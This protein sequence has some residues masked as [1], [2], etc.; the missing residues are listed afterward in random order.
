MD[1]SSR[2][3][4]LVSV[5]SGVWLFQVSGNTLVLELTAKGTKYY[6]DSDLN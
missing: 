6:K 4:D 3:T 2:S 5:S 1:R